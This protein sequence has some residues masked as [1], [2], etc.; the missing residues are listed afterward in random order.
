MC[1]YTQFINRFSDKVTKWYSTESQLA[2]HD[3]IQQYR[4]GDMF[5]QQQRKRHQK[6]KAGLLTNL[7]NLKYLIS[8]SLVSL[9]QSSLKTNNIQCKHI[10]TYHIKKGCPVYIHTRTVLMYLQI[11]K[12]VNLL[13]FLLKPYYYTCNYTPTNLHDYTPPPICICKVKSLSTRQP[14]SQ[15][16]ERVSVLS[17][18]WSSIVVQSNLIQECTFF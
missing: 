4:N 1:R 11:Y 6:Y 14:F 3:I 18:E 8:D 2:L 17:T 12:S 16:Q 9:K 13:H 5:V 7:S 15:A 10:N